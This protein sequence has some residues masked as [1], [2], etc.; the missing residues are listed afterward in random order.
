MNYLD[1]L[2]NDV[3]KIINRKVQDAQIIKRRTERKE[4]KRMQREKKQ[5]ADNKKR[6]YSKF[7]YLYERH[8][9]LEELKEKKRLKQL[10]EIEEE[11]YREKINEQ[12][13][14]LQDLILRI[15]DV[16]TDHILES[17]LCIGGEIPYLTVTFVKNNGTVYIRKFF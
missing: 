3:M 17:E 15:Y 11:K 5:I 1:I 9:F 12:H 7:V 2:P 10:E 13:K 6:I 14:Y 16:S 8:L 4:N